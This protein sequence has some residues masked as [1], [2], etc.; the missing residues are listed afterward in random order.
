MNPPKS[1]NKILAKQLIYKYT[2]HSMCM[3][4]LLFITKSLEF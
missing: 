2:V 4:S 1:L 3:Y